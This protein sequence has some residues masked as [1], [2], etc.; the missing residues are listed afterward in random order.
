MTDKERADLL[1][2]TVQSLD[3]MAAQIELLK[4]V[5]QLFLEVRK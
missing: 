3:N 5:M 2:A 1:A 4:K